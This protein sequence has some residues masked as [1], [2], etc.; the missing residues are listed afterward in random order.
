MLIIL[1][2]EVESLLHVA[3]HHS[4]IGTSKACEVCDLIG[5]LTIALSTSRST[6]RYVGFVWTREHSHQI[7]LIL[8]SQQKIT[9][10][11]REGHMSAITDRT[12]L[13]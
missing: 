4:T 1:A 8:M 9:I 2:D 6:A 12:S 11:C 10:I 7:I 5:A 3:R 13:C